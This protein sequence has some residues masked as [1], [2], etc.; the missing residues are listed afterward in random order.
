MRSRL[1]ITNHRRNFIEVD[2]QDA[3]QIGHWERETKVLTVTKPE[4]NTEM[5]P[6]AYIREGLAN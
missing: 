6:N 2:N 5:F 1:N 3:M 4:S